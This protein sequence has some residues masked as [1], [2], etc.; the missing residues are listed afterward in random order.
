[1][2]E[3]RVTEAARRNNDEE[4]L[5]RLE[6]R[7]RRELMGEEERLELSDLILKLKARAS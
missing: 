6:E 7:Y 2:D 3:G 4:R 1:M 5:G